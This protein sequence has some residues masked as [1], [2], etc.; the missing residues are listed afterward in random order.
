MSLLQVEERIADCLV[1]RA[2]EAS[3]LR[4]RVIGLEQLIRMIG[5]VTKEPD[6]L[7]LV[8]LAAKS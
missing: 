4:V 2:E 1:S 7:K 5:E 6:V 8:A 3:R